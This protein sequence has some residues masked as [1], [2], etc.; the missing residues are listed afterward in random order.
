MYN[1]RLLWQRARPSSPWSDAIR[2]LLEKQS[3]WMRGMKNESIRYSDLELG[4]N[5]SD[6]RCQD[7]LTSLISRFPV[8]SAEREI[9]ASFFERC[10]EVMGD[11]SPSSSSQSKLVDRLSIVATS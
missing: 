6:G 10:G 7:N 11:G 1:V 9:S 5:L 4:T 3:F 2:Q 8:P